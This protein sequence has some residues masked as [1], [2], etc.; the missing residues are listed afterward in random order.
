MADP[1]A[2]FENMVAG[3][4]LKY[5]HLIEDTEGYAME[6]RFLRDTDGREIDFVVLRDGRPEFAV[7]CKSGGRTASPACRYVRERSVIPRFYQV[8]LGSTD[9][10]DADSDTR[11]CHSRR[12][13]PNWRCRSHTAAHSR[14]SRAVEGMSRAGWLL[15]SRRSDLQWLRL[16]SVMCSHELH[17]RRNQNAKYRRLDTVKKNSL[18]AAT[19]STTGRSRH[20][21]VPRMKVSSWLSTL[22]PAPMRLIRTS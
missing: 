3:H 4:L 20:K 6:L 5:C 11:V 2:R 17:V 14:M 13:A 18:A 7:E 10:G 19:K 22:K 12:S 1:G 15:L 9:F 16:G 21:S 8:H